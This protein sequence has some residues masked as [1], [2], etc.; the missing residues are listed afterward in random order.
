MRTN[1]SL[2]QIKDKEQR[3]A[4][5]YCI[6]QIQHGMLCDDCPRLVRDKATSFV[7]RGKDFATGQWK[8]TFMCKQCAANYRKML[9]QLN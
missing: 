4:Y 5:K 1:P 9:A 7:M 3:A 2:S 6:E 8:V